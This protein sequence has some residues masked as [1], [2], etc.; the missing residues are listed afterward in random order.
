MEYI[1]CMVFTNRCT[2]ESA[3]SD[4]SLMN[5]YTH[6]F[7]CGFSCPPLSRRGYSTNV[8]CGLFV[9]SLREAGESVRAR[10]WLAI[11]NEREEV[12]II[13][14]IFLIFRGVK[15]NHT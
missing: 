3:T 8:P 5:S 15:I 6:G 7:V 12:A 9:R 1:F 10:N 11:I 13:Y 14:F 4:L 2:V